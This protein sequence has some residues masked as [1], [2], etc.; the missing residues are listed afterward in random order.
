M[1][2]I[3]V[4]A[5]QCSRC[6]NIWLPRGWTGEAPADQMPLCCSRCKNPGWNSTKRILPQSTV[7]PKTA[8]KRI[9]RHSAAIQQPVHT[10]SS[11][12]IHSLD[13]PVFPPPL[14]IDA[15]EEGIQR[16]NEREAKDSRAHSSIDETVSRKVGHTLGCECIAC[17]RIR[18]VLGGESAP[19]KTGIG[20]KT[21]NKRRR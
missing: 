15:P 12:S 11:P 6:G 1:P 8:R 19:K 3:T 7:K 13:S 9:R 4:Q 17:S 2:I 18:R 20:A 21:A 10:S 5:C 16:S 14:P